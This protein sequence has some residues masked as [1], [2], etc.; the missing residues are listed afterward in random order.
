MG[1]KVYECNIVFDDFSGDWLC[2]WLFVSREIFYNF[3]LI[4]VL[5]MGFCFLG[6]KN[7]VDVLLRKECV[8]VWYND[9]F[10]YLKFEVMFYV[11]CYL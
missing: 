8:F 10:F 11:G 7:G 5:L 4:L 3:S 9:F 1:L 6:Y 2:D